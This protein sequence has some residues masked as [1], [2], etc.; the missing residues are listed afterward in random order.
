MADEIA[1]PS[2]AEPTLPA[3][4]LAPVSTETFSPEERAEWMQTGKVPAPKADSTTAKPEVVKPAVIDDDSA[5]L[6][7]GKPET[8]ARFAALLADRKASKAKADALEAEVATLKKAK[9]AEPPPAKPEVKAAEPAAEPE[10]RL[11]MKEYI[12]AN[13]DKDFDDFQEYCADYSGK[14]AE[15]RAEAKFAELEQSK[16]ASERQEREAKTYNEAI[17]EAKATYPDI[18]AVIGGEPIPTTPVI[19]SYLF[20]QGKFGPVILYHLGKDV[21]NTQRIAA[22]SPVEQIEELVLM[23][24]KLLASKSEP[25]KGNVV[26]IKKP[27]AAS[28]I[29]PTMSGVSA[30]SVQDESKAALAAGDFR[31]FKE[32]EDAKDLARAKR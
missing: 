2:P 24:T 32:L 14:A 25:E 22:L 7:S 17:A 16:A 20:A 9:P 5:P 1:A 23:K 21:A 30:A 4:T 10:K 12:A 26:P 18:E 3:I 27:S 28:P 13:P 19:E 6:N 15:R 29:A 11:T 31:R 8:D